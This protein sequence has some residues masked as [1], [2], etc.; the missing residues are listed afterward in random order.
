M[1]SIPNI[2]SYIVFQSQHTPLTTITITSVLGN[3]LF[4]YLQLNWNVVYKKAIL[5]VPK[6]IFDFLIAPRLSFHA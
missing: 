6:T 4:F 1:V 2:N 3:Y 5:Y